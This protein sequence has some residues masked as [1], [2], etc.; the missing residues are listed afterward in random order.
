MQYDCKKHIVMLQTA[1]NCSVATCTILKC[2]RMNVS[3]YVTLIMI[4]ECYTKHII[5]VWPWKSIGNVDR[6]MIAWLNYIAT[7]RI[8]LHCDVNLH[9]LSVTQRI[10][11][12]SSTK[13]VKTPRN[14]GPNLLS[15]FLG[16][17]NNS[18]WSHDYWWCVTMGFSSTTSLPT[19]EQRSYSIQSKPTQQWFSFTV[20]GFLHTLNH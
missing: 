9:D 12:Q 4:V 5:F 15:C 20:G 2:S 13:S 17:A 6:K 18:S 16:M 19:L 11:L 3:C 1:L 7:H 10:E 14:E 8:K